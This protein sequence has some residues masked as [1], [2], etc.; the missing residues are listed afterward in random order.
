MPTHGLKEDR[1]KY[2]DYPP[3]QWLDPAMASH[4]SFRK[5]RYLIDAM[6]S[7]A[8]VAMDPLRETLLFHP[9]AAAFSFASVP[10]WRVTAS[11][12][13]PQFRT[14]ASPVNAHGRKQI[15]LGNLYSV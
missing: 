11:R 15:I 7:P 13:N 4:S 1:R 14:P 2:F 3:S 6:L 5:P 8:T 9:V 12:Q 10:L